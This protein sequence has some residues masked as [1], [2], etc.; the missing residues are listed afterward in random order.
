MDLRVRIL[1]ACDKR[2]WTQ[3]EVAERF[4][5]SVGMVKKLLGKRRHQG[6][7]APGY[8]RCGRKS[9][10]TAAHRRQLSEALKRQSDLTL[11]EMREELGL[12]CSLA[13]IHYLLIKMGLSLK[14]RR[15]GL[16]NKGDATLR[17]AAGSGA[18]A[19][20]AGSLTA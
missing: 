8:R 16:P 17:K 3:K 13:A 9:I 4:D 5:V 14:K 10:F 2:R 11:A 7:I 6:E 12:D 18:A 15:C 20:K 19:K 1:A